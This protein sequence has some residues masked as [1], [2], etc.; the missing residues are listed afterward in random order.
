MV[1]RAYSDLCDL[2]LFWICIHLPY[3]IEDSGT[4]WWPK[5]VFSLI[6]LLYMVNRTQNTNGFTQRNGLD[7]ELM[8]IKRYSNIPKLIVVVDIVVTAIVVVI[9][10]DWFDS[11]KI[12]S[13]KP[14]SNGKI[15]LEMNRN[16]FV[17]PVWTHN[18]ECFIFF[19]LSVNG[20][21]AFRHS[22]H[23]QSVFYRCFAYRH[24]NAWQLYP[25]IW[26]HSKHLSIIIFWF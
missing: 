17:L 7:F 12:R 23:F 20:R 3:K 6:N 2:L 8:P 18:C 4:A 16:L 13:R 10:L 21:H 5:I 11:L 24:R 22:W 9:V 1:S 26:V 14:K 19:I 15:K 25:M